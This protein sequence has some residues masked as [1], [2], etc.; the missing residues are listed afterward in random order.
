[1]TSPANAFGDIYTNNTI[2][3]S[4]GFRILG[5]AAY[6]YSGHAAVPLVMSTAMVSMM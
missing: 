6:S 5:P 1:V 2:P 4:V 3:S